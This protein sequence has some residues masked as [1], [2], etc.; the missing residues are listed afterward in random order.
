MLCQANLSTGRRAPDTEE[1]RLLL[2]CTSSS[3]GTK[4]DGE[5]GRSRSAN[6]ASGSP[7]K[8][9]IR[10]EARLPILHN[11][12]HSVLP[13]YKVISHSNGARRSHDHA[14]VQIYVS[15]LMLTTEIKATIMAINGDKNLHACL[16]TVILQDGSPYPARVP[17]GRRE[18][19]GVSEG[20]R[21]PVT[22]EATQ[23][24]SGRGTTTSG[25]R[26]SSCCWLM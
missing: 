9:T 14:A 12:Q 7:E 13:A 20:L 21:P 5:D 2:S 10:R 16:W 22:L 24:C 17:M 15:P 4:G 18:G 8:S 11:A 19:A 1:A 23:L 25:G 3:R 26:H 6:A